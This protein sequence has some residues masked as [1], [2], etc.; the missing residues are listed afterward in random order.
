[1]SDYLFSLHRSH[2][3]GSHAPACKFAY[4]YRTTTVENIYVQVL[5]LAVRDKNLAARAAAARKNDTPETQLDTGM[6]LGSL[7]HQRDRYFFHRNPA[8]K[9]H[10][11]RRSRLIW[12]NRKSQRRFLEFDGLIDNRK[13]LTLAVAEYQQ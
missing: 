8:R 5:V 2:R 3:I 13:P 12:K 6:E 1:M 9:T 7:A 10:D 11:R 4:D